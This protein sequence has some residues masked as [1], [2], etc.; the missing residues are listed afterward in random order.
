MLNGSILVNILGKL[1]KVI[2]NRNAGYIVNS[3]VE[4]LTSALINISSDYERGYIFTERI[5]HSRGTKET[6]FLGADTIKS[7]LKSLV[8]N[9]RIEGRPRMSALSYSGRKKVTRRRRKKF[10]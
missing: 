9:V 5:L 1:N 3:D 2:E 8:P 6:I 10:T 7:K 4:E